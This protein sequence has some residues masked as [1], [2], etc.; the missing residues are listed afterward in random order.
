MAFVPTLSR[1]Y[2]IRVTVRFNE[3]PPPHVHVAYQN[4]RASI[5]I[6]TLDILVGRLP[7]RARILFL[8]WAMLH[9]EELRRAWTAASQ[10][11][12]P[13]TIEPLS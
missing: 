4:D 13:G 1:F 6:E 3:H 12:N 8:E 7:G 9:R 2:G 10:R 5:S 11:R